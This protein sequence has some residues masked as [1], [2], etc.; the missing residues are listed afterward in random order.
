MDSRHNSIL[1]YDLWGSINSGKSNIIDL[2]FV[3]SASHCL[4]IQVVKTTII[5]HLI[6][7]S[8]C[9]V[10]SLTF[11]VTLP[12]TLK[13]N[14][15]NLHPIGC[16]PLLQQQPPIGCNF[17][18]QKIGVQNCT[19]IW[20]ADLHPQRCKKSTLRGANEHPQGCRPLL[21]QQPPIGVQNC[22]PLWVQTCTLQVAA[23]VAAVCTPKGARLHPSLGCR[24]VPYRVQGFGV[25][26]CSLKS[27]NI[28]PLGCKQAPLGVQIC[29]IYMVQNCTLQGAHGLLT[30]HYNQ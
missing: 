6:L 26:N 3:E 12:Y 5:I 20:G 2:F 22:T 1:W 13:N 16:R 18:P 28:H 25:H 15:T 4:I 27:A 30:S 24:L 17:V 10:C 8:H 23:I 7:E 21:Q 19:L 11:S 9:Q 14:G 29:N